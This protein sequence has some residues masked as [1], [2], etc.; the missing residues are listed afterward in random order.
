[1]VKIQ[2]YTAAAIDSKSRLQ[3]NHYL[4]E[5]YNLLPVLRKEIQLR[6][7][8]LSVL[9]QVSSSE[10]RF[11]EDM[12]KFCVTIQSYF[13]ELH[14]IMKNASIGKE[15]KKK[16][17]MGLLSSYS[18]MEAPKIDK[19]D[20]NSFDISFHT[21]NFQAITTKMNT[22]STLTNVPISKLLQIAEE[23]VDGL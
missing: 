15:T 20:P 5:L 10:K 21:I 13:E 12:T 3:L 19:Y 18:W 6:Q 1:M 7:A 16:S 8:K 14:K 2:N 17:I 4:S 11:N 23:M 22:Q 9:Q